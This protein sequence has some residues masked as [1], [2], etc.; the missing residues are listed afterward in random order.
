MMHQAG[1]GPGGPPEGGVSRLLG[2][3]PTPTPTHLS[4]LSGLGTIPLA[5]VGLQ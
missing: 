4:S 2:T 3:P 1:K 5:A